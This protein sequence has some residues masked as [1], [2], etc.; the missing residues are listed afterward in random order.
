MCQKIPKV[1]ADTIKYLRSEEFK[2][3]LTKKNLPP[4]M[5][6]ATLSLLETETDQEI[7]DYV[8]KL[9][10]AGMQSVRAYFEGANGILIPFSGGRDS[11]VL[12][13]LALRAFQFTRIT[14]MTC[15]TGMYRGSEDD[16]NIPRRQAQKIFARH[17]NQNN[18]THEYLD[19]SLPIGRFVVD[20]AKKHRD[21][22]GYPSFCTDCKLIMEACLAALAKKYGYDCIAYGYAEYQAAQ[23]WTE[24]TPSFRY[25]MKL[26]AD[27]NYTEIMVCSPLQVVLQLPIDS[28]LLLAYLGVEIEEQKNEAKCSAGGANPVKIDPIVLSS[29]LQRRINRLPSSEEFA[30]MFRRSDSPIASY[31]HVQAIL[32]L[33]KEPSYMEGAFREEGDRHN[34]T[35]DPAQ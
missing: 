25:A 1:L 31:N 17:P 34:F 10:D 22:L 14:L 33:K 21:E 19:I 16:L 29:C 35:E 13:E 20:V 18:G 11:T 12:T 27:K 9:Y 26:F 4:E 32:D 30:E 24:Q 8:S 7:M 28:I 2:Q 5:L 3:K 6:V 15:C 23:Q